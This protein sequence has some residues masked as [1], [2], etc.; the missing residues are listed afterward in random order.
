MAQSVSCYLPKFGNAF[1]GPKRHVA[2]RAKGSPAQNSELLSLWRRGQ[3]SS[4]LQATWAL[5]LHCYTSSEDVCFGYQH[6]EVDGSHKSSVQAEECAHNSTVRLSI[7]KGDS[8]GAIVSR[9]KANCSPGNT[10]EVCG[11]ANGVSD[12]DRLFN[13]TLMLRTYADSTDSLHS[14]RAQ[15]AGAI[16]LPEDVS[17][18]R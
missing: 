11:G 13:T 4:T 12:G 14:S 2:I 18:T 8:L 7:H 15:P 6:V 5:V 16:A 9:A 1:Q 10:S 3:L 17:A